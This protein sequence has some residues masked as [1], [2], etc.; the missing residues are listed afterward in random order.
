MNEYRTE[1]GVPVY[2][3]TRGMR[4]MSPATG[5]RWN[6]LGELL[7]LSMLEENKLV[8]CRVVFI[9]RSQICQL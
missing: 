6:Q 2:K 4:D 7:G 8:R 5:T 9:L 1:I 3:V